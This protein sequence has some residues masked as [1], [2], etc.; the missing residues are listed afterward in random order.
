MDEPEGFVKILTGDTYNEI[1]GAHIVGARATD[2]IAE[3]SLAISAECTAE[4]LVQTVHAHPTIS[5][6]VF[7][8]A[9]IACFGQTV[10]V[11]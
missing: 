5:E 6:A 8:A 7:E 1:L 10:H 9:E 3:L 4:E 11:I 2:L